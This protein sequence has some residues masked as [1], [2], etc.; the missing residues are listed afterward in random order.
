MTQGLYHQLL[1]YLALDTHFKTPL[2]SPSLDLIF[3]SFVNKKKKKQW[4]S[5]WHFQKCHSQMLKKKNSN[6]KPKKS[7]DEAASLKQYT[8]TYLTFNI[9]TKVKMFIN[10][11]YKIRDKRDVICA[12][13]FVVLHFHLVTNRGPT[14]CL[15]KIHSWGASVAVWF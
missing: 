7:D 11:T 6:V 10:F 9:L 12:T 4:S 13:G 14:L 15:P 3:N 5:S 1:R 2:I 8:A